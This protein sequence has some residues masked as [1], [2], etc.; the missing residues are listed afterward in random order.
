MKISEQI[1]VK[2][3]TAITRQILEKIA[4]KNAE[5]S[6]LFEIFKTK[7]YQNFSPKNSKTRV[8]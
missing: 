5:K 2:T 7:F 3:K 1:G 6:L 8:F 4:L